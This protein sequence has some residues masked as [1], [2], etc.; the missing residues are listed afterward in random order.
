MLEFEALRVP[1][2]TEEIALSL[3]SSL[4][5][6]PG[7]TQIKI[8]LTFQTIQIVFDEEQ[9]GFLTLTQAMARAGCPLRHINAAL[10]KNHS[11]RE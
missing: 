3:E 1:A 10:L 4:K 8:D 2:L 7:V 11:Q 6:L 9:L 5:S